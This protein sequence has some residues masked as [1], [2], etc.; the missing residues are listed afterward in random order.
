MSIGIRAAGIV[1]ICLFGTSAL[2]ADTTAWRGAEKGK[3]RLVAGARALDGSLH[4]GLQFKLADGWKTYWRV[5]GDSGVPPAF[6]WKASVNARS[7]DLLWPV[8]SR[9]KDNFGWNNG[10]KKSTLFPIRIVPQS[11]NAPVELNLTVH[12]GVCRELC[13]PGKANLSLK[14]PAEGSSS[15]QALIGRYLQMVPRAVTQNDDLKVVGVEAEKANDGI[16]LLVKVRQKL[17]TPLEVFLEGPDTLYFET[18]VQATSPSGAERH[19]RVRV[20]GAKSLS[21]L[22]G[23]EL[24]FT[25]SQDNLRLEQPWSLD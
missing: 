2:A 6:N 12:Y 14:I 25:L 15:H 20:D 21:D 5:P 9:F 4:A 24:R 8:P 10:Y 3:V 17:E 22:K 18:P 23:A 19:Y 13:I 7:I 1:L 11:S 16:A